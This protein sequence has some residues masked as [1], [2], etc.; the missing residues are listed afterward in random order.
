MKEKQTAIP[1]IQNKKIAGNK[2]RQFFI[3]VA[4]STLI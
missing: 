3:P 4:I 2:D 1:V